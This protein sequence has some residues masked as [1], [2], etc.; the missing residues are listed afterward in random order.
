MSKERLITGASNSNG[1]IRLNRK[2][3]I[4]WKPKLKNP[5]LYRCFKRQT[6]EIEREKR[7]AWLRKGN[8]K[9]KTRPL[10]IAA[11]N[12]ALRTNYIKVKI[13]KTQ[14]PSKRSLCGYR[15]K[16]VNHI[17]RECSK[18][19]QKEYKIKHDWVGKVIHWELN[20]RLKFDHTTTWYMQNPE[21]IL[22]NETQ[23]ILLD[24]GI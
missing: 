14:Q 17:I 2:T 24:F 10:F 19:A 13:D 3:K 18:L 7:W 6:G 5:Q 21:S 1:N 22:S 12:N 11:Q 16:T 20:K 9:R 15:D 23:K 8:L 4:T